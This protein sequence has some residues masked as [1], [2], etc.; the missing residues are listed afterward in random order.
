MSEYRRFISYMYAYD[1]GIKNKN[2]GFAKTERRGE[3]VKLWI[4]LKGAYSQAENYKVYFFVRH[5]GNIV[6]ICMGDM[7]IKSGMG[8]FFVAKPLTDIE[9]PFDNICGLYIG[10]EPGERMF[11]SQWDDMPFDTKRVMDMEAYKVMLLARENERE[12][13]E[14]TVKEREAKKQTIGE[15]AV[16]AVSGKQAG[17]TESDNAGGAKEPESRGVAATVETPVWEKP[18]KM[19]YISDGERITRSENAPAVDN[20]MTNEETTGKETVKNEPELHVSEE[21]S[22]PE[23]HSKLD[24]LFDGKEPVLAFS[25]DDIYDCVDIGLDE[26]P[27]IDTKD[28]SLINNSF[29]NH[30]YFNF[31][32]LLLGKKDGNILVVGVPGIYNRREKIT[33]NMFGFEKFKFSMRSDVCMNHFGY[34]YKEYQYS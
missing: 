16:K 13:K 31:H 6:G 3:T 11:A 7:V 30:G 34:W 26:L 32:H 21:V 25:E 17:E 12:E 10:G 14:R 19:V 1:N 2:V 4:N 22:C 24:M 28:N 33:A 9:L 18:I 23:K 29:V 5:D 15:S 27:K 8:Q 20:T